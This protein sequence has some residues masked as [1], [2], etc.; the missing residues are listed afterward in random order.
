MRTLIELLFSSNSSNTYTFTKDMKSAL[1]VAMADNNVSVSLTSSTGSCNTV[2]TSTVGGGY[3]N[4]ALVFAHISNPSAN[5]VITVG[6]GRFSALHI[7]GSDKNDQIDFTRLWQS[8]LPINQEFNEDTEM[9][10]L[11]DDKYDVVFTFIGMGE[12]DEMTHTNDTGPGTN[13]A[14]IFSHTGHDGTTQGYLVTSYATNVAA[15]QSCHFYFE[16]KAWSQ[17]G[18]YELN[19][20]TA[21]SYGLK[22]K[23]INAYYGTKEINSVFFGT[24]EVSQLFYGQKEI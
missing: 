11:P 23:G 20:H 8:S 17:S 3:I 22:I 6:G 19:T 2:A 14:T 13:T 9:N 5:D 16:N 4:N 18:D 1:V 24:K 15:D 21:I 7:Y 12:K 10:L